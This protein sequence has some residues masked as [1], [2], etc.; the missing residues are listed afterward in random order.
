MKVLLKRFHLN[1][2]SKEF[3]PETQKLKLKRCGSDGVK[4]LVHSFR[5]I[6]GISPLQ[7]FPT[8]FGPFQ[9]INSV[10]YKVLAT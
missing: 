3:Y 6:G 9:D 1:G 4:T 8:H 2:H 10:H 7:I 5:E